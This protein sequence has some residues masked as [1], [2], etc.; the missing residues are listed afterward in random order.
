LKDSL[1]N[2]NN[3]Q[4]TI[5]LI[6]E[7]N[8]NGPSLLDVPTREALSQ[9]MRVAY[10]EV[11]NQKLPIRFHSAITVL[12]ASIQMLKAPTISNLKV[13]ELT[14]KELV[15]FLD[16]QLVVQKP[17][18]PYTQELFFKNTISREKQIKDMT[19]GII[20][21]Y[22]ACC[23]KLHRCQ[24]DVI[25][26]VRGPVGS[27]KTHFLHYATAEIVRRLKT[28]KG[29]QNDAEKKFS[30]L[31]LI[32][33]SRY[34]ITVPT[35]WLNQLVQM[36]E[37]RLQ[38]FAS[39]R[40]ELS[41]KN[42]SAL[43]ANQYIAA[44]LA[45]HCL[46][47]NG[48]VFATD[49]FKT[50]PLSLPEV[51]Q[52]IKERYG[53]SLL[54]EVDIDE[55]QM[56]IDDD[57]RQKISAHELLHKLHNITAE[58]R[59][60][61]FLTV[62]GGTTFPEKNNIR[63]VSLTGPST[64]VFALGSLGIRDTVLN[65]MSREYPDETREIIA[66]L[67]S[68]VDLA[69]LLSLIGPFPRTVEM[70]IRAVWEL[71][72]NNTPIT[73]RKLYQTVRE[74]LVMKYEMKTESMLSASTDE[75][76]LV[77]LHILQGREVELHDRT[78]QEALL[79]GLVSYDNST[80]SI[81]F[82]YLHIALC[83]NDNIKQILDTSF[84]DHYVD[85][86]LDGGTHARTMED[87]IGQFVA[88]KTRLYQVSGQ[89]TVKA[90]IF[91]KGASL[92]NKIH[93]VTLELG[94]TQMTSYMSTH[95]TEDYLKDV[96]NIEV[97]HTRINMKKTAVSLSIGNQYPACDG[98]ISFLKPF[99]GLEAKKLEN[100]SCVGIISKDSFEHEQDKFEKFI[101]INN[102]DPPVL[103]LYCSAGVTNRTQFAMVAHDYSMVVERDNWTE[104]FKIL[105]KIYMTKTQ[106][107]N[108]LNSSIHFFKDIT[109]TVVH[110]P[111]SNEELSDRFNV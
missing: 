72:K 12:W 98:L 101:K 53:N 33:C 84:L 92:G 54:I 30:M 14:G 21:Q 8:F 102:I 25:F 11:H 104:F 59:D 36:I 68:D 55:I 82:L 91:F 24:D 103:F 70:L 22:I 86:V 67:G 77:L 108:I 35:N 88:F 7:L 37:N 40:N 100:T 106:L 49:N 51:L 78:V 48:Y 18:V 111:F 89:R 93:S 63:F 9:S 83:N 95:S 90:D 79:R 46:A 3:V 19:A 42:F 73:A 81:I 76:A 61:L 52:L 57:N 43:N 69:N 94:D 28:D 97:N 17:D 32:S 41:W 62:F 16:K 107:P 23:L 96:T 109:P 39:Q 56:L 2:E 5:Q 47:P 44:L 20:R 29:F 1:E 58:R 85:A 10:Q 50:T 74:M 99:V 13:Q 34:N 27:G 15:G 26:K 64:Y 6:Q 31:W 65:L 4:T 45:I 80:L 105:P 66:H 38:V 87:I 71:K 60:I 75:L 110:R